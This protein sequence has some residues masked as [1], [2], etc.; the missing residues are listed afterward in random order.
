MPLDPTDGDANFVD[1]HSVAI[2]FAIVAPYSAANTTA[3]L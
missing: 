3:D 1:P 2:E